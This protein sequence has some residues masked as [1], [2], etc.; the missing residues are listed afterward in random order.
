MIKKSMETYQA[1]DH[2]NMQGVTTAG[3]SIQ[4]V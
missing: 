2:G 3:G 4:S 1:T